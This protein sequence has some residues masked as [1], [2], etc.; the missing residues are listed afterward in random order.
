MYT[1]IFAGISGAFPVLEFLEELAIDNLV[2]IRVFFHL[3]TVHIL[4]YMCVYN[5]IQFVDIGEMPTH[6]TR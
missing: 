3:F 6:T 4:V 2:V 5:S 1:C